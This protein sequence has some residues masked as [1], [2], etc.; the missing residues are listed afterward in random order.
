M[1]SKV[2][3]IEKK[4]VEMENFNFFME[5]RPFC[6]SKLGPF[7]LLWLLKKVM[8]VTKFIL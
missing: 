1:Q 5:W 8:K 3:T 6:K 4:E 2:A 7:M